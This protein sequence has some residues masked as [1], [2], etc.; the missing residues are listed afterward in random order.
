MTLNDQR[1]AHWR[2][3]AKLKADTELVVA[4]AI[5]KAKLGKLDG[6]VEVSLVWYAPDA[7]KRDPDGLAPMAKA[8]LDA[9][10]KKGVLDD[11][12]STVVQS[13][14]LGPIVISRDRPRFEFHIRLVE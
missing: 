14:R 4:E 7:R 8:I 11:D 5:K 12:D 13:V 10:V 2:T 3:V 9:L 1:R 6:P